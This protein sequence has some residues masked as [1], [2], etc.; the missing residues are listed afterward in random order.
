MNRLPP[1]EFGT[2]GLAAKAWQVCRDPQPRA[3]EDPAPGVPLGLAN[4]QVPEMRAGN[5]FDLLGRIERGLPGFSTRS[6]LC[7]NTRSDPH[8]LG[9]SVCGG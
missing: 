1:I 7:A 4:R 2:G 8:T 5:G 3:P 6:V 9:D